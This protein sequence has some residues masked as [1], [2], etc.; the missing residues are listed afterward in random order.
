MLIASSS[1]L[2]LISK[3]KLG[4][5]PGY[6]LLVVATDAV[7]AFPPVLLAACILALKRR[8]GLNIA[9]GT[10]SVLLEGMQY[11]TTNLFGTIKAR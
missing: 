3:I 11:V 7:I 8:F 5:A 10:L 6:K 2:L 9:N 1:R 4:Q